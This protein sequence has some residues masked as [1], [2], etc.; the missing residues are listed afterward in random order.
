MKEW[1]SLAW[2]LFKNMVKQ[3]I[4]G[5]FSESKEAY[6]WLSVHLSY[7]SKRIG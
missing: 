3:F 4:L 1:L 6:Y 5:N 2:F 7:K